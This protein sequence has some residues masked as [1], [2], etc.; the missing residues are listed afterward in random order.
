M[1]ILTRRPIIAM[2]A[3]FGF[4]AAALILYVIPKGD[5]AVPQAQAIA[6][7]TSPS[8]TPHQI[9]AAPK[10][11]PAI[12]QQPEAKAAD[13]A[14]APIEKPMPVTVPKVVAI[15][16]AGGK[17]YNLTPNELGGFDRIFIAAGE[18]VKVT[19]S[20]ELGI[21]GEPLLVEA[22]DGGI[23]DGGGS[24][25]P[26]A[27]D[28]DRGL[29]FV[30]KASTQDG[31][32]RVTMRRF[33]GQEAPPAVPDPA[34]LPGAA[35]GVIAPASAIASDAA[36]KSGAPIPSTKD[37]AAKPGA[38]PG[39]ASTTPAVPPLPSL[40]DQLIVFD[41][42]VGEPLKPAAPLAKEPDLAKLR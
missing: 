34:A 18:E 42:W 33:I 36:K 10:P 22:E 24:A 21:P 28:P 6:S 12:A 37:L 39:V 26:K 31:I 41:F 29:S 16:V 38:T 8:L 9:V 11:A 19:A 14:P 23:I 13:Q 27:L 15:V 20:Y 3:V 1:K 2:I 32:H 30:F 40:V 35:A 4:I 5:K 7:T 25:S 17:T